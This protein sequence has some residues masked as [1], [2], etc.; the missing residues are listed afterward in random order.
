MAAVTTIAIASLALAA[1]G[2]GVAV[3]GQVK[4]AETA[5]KMGEYN[6]KLAEN[7]A[8]Q[9]EMDSR[10]QLRRSAIGNKRI[11]ATQRVSYAKAGVD[12]AGTPLAVMA[13]TA[14]NLKL[15]NLDYMKKTGQDVTALY[16]QAGA[17]RA[18]GAQQAQAA[19]IGAGASLLQGGASMASMGYGM[20]RDAKMDTYYKTGAY[21][22]K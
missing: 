6:A 16:G 3:Y 8:L 4:Q 1:V 19:Y 11:M 14:G 9:T 2:T 21:P 5:K 13:E 15:S 7:Q 18:M 12:T 22:T 17:S 10:E 20:Q